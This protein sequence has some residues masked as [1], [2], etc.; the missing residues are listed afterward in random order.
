MDGLNYLNIVCFSSQ[1]KFL[2]MFLKVICERNVNI[3]INSRE[4]PRLNFKLRF[5]FYIV[6]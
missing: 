6:E 5:L 2:E 3:G 1:E 4:L